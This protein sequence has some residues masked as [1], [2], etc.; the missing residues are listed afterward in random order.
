MSAL[1]AT[2]AS[3]RVLVRRA[4]NEIVRVP[5]AGIPSMIAPSFF[6]LGTTA[7]FGHL[8]QL[9]GFPTDKYLEF[10]MPISMMQAAG[11]TGTATG[12]NLAR[13]IEHGWF[14][15]MLLSPA[16]RILLIAANVASAGIRSLLPVPFT[17]GVGFALGVRWPGL[18]ALLVSIGLAMG[19]AVVAATWASSMAL[20][21][22]TQSAAPLFQTS[23][24]VSVL[25]STSYAPQSLLTGFLKDVARW[26]PVT[27]VVEG[28]RQGFVG[29]LAWTTTWH[30]LAVLVGLALVAGALALRNLA[31]MGD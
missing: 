1:P 22:R 16:P 27:K 7:V 11:F 21:F 29:D 14:D 23:V 8:T 3:G 5:A 24:F 15:R 2:L 17:L 26:N 20:Y 28:V 4:L 12:V 25:F 31:R 9:R 10:V 6:M 13:D 18:G 19:F 30:A